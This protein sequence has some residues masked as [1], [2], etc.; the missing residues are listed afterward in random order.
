VSVTGGS[1]LASVSALALLAIR[2]FQRWRSPLKGYCCAFS[3]LHGGPGCSG[4]AADAIAEH[5]LPGAIGPI[6]R[7]FR[8]CRAAAVALFAEP[9]AARPEG[10]RPRAVFD[11]LFRYAVFAPGLARGG[12]SL[13]VCVLG[14]LR[15]VR[16][17]ARSE[18]GF[19]NG[20]VRCCAPIVQA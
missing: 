18:D 5:G 16:F 15:V 14:A 17:C 19:A 20:S 9:R 2:E 8:E 7:R 4:F 3:I 11:Q 6:R 12:Y 10:H 13:S 1:R